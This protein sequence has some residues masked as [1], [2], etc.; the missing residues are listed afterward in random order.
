MH[1][2][3]T[4]HPLTVQPPLPDSPP[5]ALQILHTHAKSLA[6][7]ICVWL[8]LTLQAALFFTPTYLPVILV[9]ASFFSP[10]K[11]L[12]YS[13]RLSFCLYGVLFSIIICWD[14]ITEH[15]VSTLASPFGFQ[16]PVWRYSRNHEIWY[17]KIRGSDIWLLQELHS[18]F[19]T[20]V[21]PSPLCIARN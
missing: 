7:R 17:N 19:Y 20:T 9:W 14:G 15:P 13:W 12:C 18:G 4:H 3:Q 2:L 6:D 10:W 5:D 16:N 1:A 8:L 21:S 11:P